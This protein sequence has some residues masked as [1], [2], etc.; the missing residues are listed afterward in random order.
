MVEKQQYLY[1]GRLLHRRN[2]PGGRIQGKVRAVSKAAKTYHSCTAQVAILTCQEGG[3]QVEKGMRSRGGAVPAE[4]TL[5][6]PRK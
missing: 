4:E 6:N 1:K 5:R 3:H 2:Q